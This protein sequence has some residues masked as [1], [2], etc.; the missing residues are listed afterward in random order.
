MTS[1]AKDSRTG[2]SRD[3]A[4]AY[5]LIMR[6][7]QRLLAPS[8]PLRF[9]FSHSALREGW[10]NPNVFT[11]CTL[12]ESRSEVRKR[13]EIG[14]GL[15]LPVSVDGR[16][17]DDPDVARLTIVA[18]ESYDDFAAALQTEIEDETGV[19]FAS[20]SIR[21]ARERRTVRLRKDYADNKGFLALWERIKHRTRYRVSYD[22][23]ELVD[24]AAAY[25]KE[26]APVPSIYVRTTRTPLDITDDGVAAAK[27]AFESPAVEVGGNH[28]IPDIVGHLQ[29]HQ[30]VSRSTIVAL[31]VASER[32]GEVAK[33][34]A[35]FLDV[36]GRAIEDVLHD[37]LVDGIVYER[38]AVGPDAVYDLRLFEDRELTAYMDNIVEVDHSPYRDVV[39]ESDVERDIALA[40]DAREDIKLFL[41]LPGWF[42]V[43]TPIG[44]YN[45]DWA[46]V[47][48]DDGGVDRFYLVRESKSE[49][50][51]QDLRPDER[52]KILFGKRHFHALD[53]DFTWINSP[54]QI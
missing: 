35:H 14:R 9:I 13:Q 18:N 28:S 48:T 42:T 11:I 20:S 49:M 24:R 16:R 10:D 52:R 23:S 37:L 45:P 4:D 51:L 12:N 3:D 54:D 15:R 43:A 36:A 38:V 22:T 40:L 46:I 34:P 32:L 31:V 44:P 47:K 5:E 30:A 27:M 53:V 21:N 39:Y 6:D 19:T 17:C 1:Q 41:K 29:R 26:A 7:K 8:E 50:N 33:N 25:L 2:R